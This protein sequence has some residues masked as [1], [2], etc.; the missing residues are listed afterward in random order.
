MNAPRPTRRNEWGAS[1][2]LA[3]LGLGESR[4]A[5]GLAGLGGTWGPVDE[6]ESLATI[7]QALEKGVGV[8]DTAPAYGTSEKLFGQALAQWRGPR[9]VISTKV[10]RLPG[11]DSHDESYDFSVAGIRRSLE[12]SLELL[13]VPRVDLLF[14]HEP[15][16]VPP[17][18]RPRVVAALQQLQVDG[19]AGQLGIGGGW[20]ADWDG[21]VEH[22]AFAVMMLFRRIDPC[23]FNG[24]T[25]D[26]PRLHRANMATYG[27]SPLHMGLL[28]ARHEQ[29]LRERPEWVWGPQIER[30]I[31]LKMIAEMHGLALSALAHRFTFSI[32][33]LDR[34]VI[35]ASN[36]R[37]LESALADFA[38]G[39]LPE[40]VFGEVC[41][42]A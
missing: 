22:G 27:A 12:R 11:R 15:Q 9:P 36:L 30:A 42:L 3:K 26:L 13:G 38:A 2:R 7:L 10:G 6:G 5:L 25:E 19:L 35:G 16:R 31:Q 34:V 40:D 29:F 8:F 21:L 17:L 39:P 32:A 24:V 37:E 33:E 18:E 14:L 28:G 20:G 23:I 41:G 4:L 1:T